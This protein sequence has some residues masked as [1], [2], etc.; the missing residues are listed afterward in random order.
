MVA[1]RSGAGERVVKHGNRAASSACG[2]AD[3][4][5][6]L[7]VVLS[8]PPEQ[9]AAVGTDVALSAATQPNSP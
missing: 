4:L 7:G 2:T 8:L 9:V 5:E 6:E 1:H 3:V